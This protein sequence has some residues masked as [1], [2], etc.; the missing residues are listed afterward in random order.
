MARGHQI[1]WFCGVD[2]GGPSLY[3]TCGL[4]ANTINQEFGDSFIRYH[5]ASGGLVFELE[6]AAGGVNHL[7]L[8]SQAFGLPAQ[9]LAKGTSTDVDIQLVTQGAGGRIWTGPFTAG[10]GTVA[11]WVEMKDDAGVTRK[12]AILS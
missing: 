7:S 3:S 4:A 10:A 8:K 1:Q 12:F 9:V 2:Q 6:N 11:G 5:N